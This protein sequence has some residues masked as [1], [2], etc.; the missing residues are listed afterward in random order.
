MHVCCLSASFRSPQGI[1]WAHVRNRQ[2]CRVHHTPSPTPTCTR[3]SH[4][5]VEAGPKVQPLGRVCQNAHD[6]CDGGKRA[7]NARKPKGCQNRCMLVGAPAKSCRG[8][9]RCASEGTAEARVA[10]RY[11]ST[12]SSTQKK[13]QEVWHQKS[14]QPRIGE[15][16]SVRMTNDM[17]VTC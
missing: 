15:W 10:G 2:R 16:E 14:P 1:C 6:I 17:G 11:E 13:H 4:N 12:S 8:R 9:K 7:S 5:K 3:L